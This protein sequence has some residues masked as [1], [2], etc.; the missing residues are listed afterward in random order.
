MENKNGL[1]IDDGHVYSAS[2]K[3]Y[4][5]LA[6]K[7]RDDLPKRRLPFVKHVKRGERT[8]C[9]FTWPNAA[10]R[11][12]LPAPDDPGFDHA[13]LVELA[14]L[15]GQPEPAR[16]PVESN[17]VYFIGGAVGGIK[18]GFARDVGRRF[19]N[20]QSCSPIP[21]ELLAAVT[22]TMKTERDYHLRFAEHRLHGEWFSPAPDI[23]AEIARLSK[24][25]Q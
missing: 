21:L 8:Y 23:L 9:Y 15:E 25:P 16:P 7:G 17:T 3:A 12:P 13:Y 20:I 5:R 22:G 10:A 11:H 18:I 14:R 19:A 1:R 24:G 2:G 6:C 4:P